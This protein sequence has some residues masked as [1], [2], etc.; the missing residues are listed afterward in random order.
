[1][2]K[3]KVD[4]YLLTNGKNFPPESLAFLRERLLNADDDKYVF[5]SSADIKEPTVL[6]IVSLLLGSLGI[7]M[8]MLGDTG[9]GVLKL[10]TGGVC[11]IMTIVDWFLVSRRAREKN[12]QKVLALL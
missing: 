9:L 4:L 5:L 2:T 10:L 7:D 3:E 1:M 11:G 12:L 8:F 6:L